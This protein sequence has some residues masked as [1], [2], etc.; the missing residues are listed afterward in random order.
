MD[1]LEDPERQERRGG[2]RE[3]AGRKPNANYNLIN[4]WTNLQTAKVT[5]EK[6]NQYQ[7]QLNGQSP[8]AEVLE[9]IDKL[10]IK[11]QRELDRELAE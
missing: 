3:G 6:D 11:L 1:S 9:I 4:A 2:F 8:Y 5:L 7:K 10:L